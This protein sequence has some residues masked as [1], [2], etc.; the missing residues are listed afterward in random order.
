MTSKDTCEGE[1]PAERLLC[2]VIDALEGHT[3]IVSRSGVILGVNRRW[4]EAVA[5]ALPGSAGAGADFFAYCVPG[6]PLLGPM[7]TE[8]ASR[9]RQV[10]SGESGDQAIKH[11]ME[12]DGQVRWLVVRM[13]RVHHSDAAAVL[14][15]VDITEGMRTQEELRRVTEE[16]T[17]LAL[18]AR[19]TDNAVL[20]TDAQGV[21]E[22]ANDAFTRT[23]G[24]TTEEIVGTRRRDLVR[25]P[26]TRTR[27]FD[28]LFARV[29]AGRSVDSEFASQTKQGRPYWVNLEV[30]PT[31][32]QGRVARMVWVERDVT[33]R[34]ATE[35]QIRQ[36]VGTAQSL[37]EALAHEKV[38][39]AN[40]MSTIPHLVYWKDRDLRYVGCN[41]AFLSARG[42]AGETEVVGRVEGQMDV[43]DSLSSVLPD[44]EQRVLATGAPV[45]DTTVRMSDPTGAPCVL[46]ISVLPQRRAGGH[47]DGTDSHIEGVIGVAS[48]ITH[49]S[50]LERQLAQ[51]A[52]LE[53]IGQLAAGIAHEINTPLQYVCDNTRFV[54]DMFAD[55]LAA[56]RNDATGGPP[57]DLDFVSAEIPGALTQSLEGLDRVRNIVRAMKDFSYPG[58]GLG[59][60]NLN[61]V[62]ES[63][64]QVSRSEWKYVAE[65]ALALDPDL[66]MV[67]CY[68]GELKQALLNIVVNAAQAIGEHRERNGIVELGHITVSTA[69]DGDCVRV[70][71]A[72]DGPGMAEDVRARIFDH[73][74]TT[75]EVGKGTGQGLSM[76]H[77]VVVTKHG[78]TLEV[79][80]AP[81]RGA[82]FTITLPVKVAAPVEVSA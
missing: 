16:A 28:E 26:F 48:D 8:V 1:R 27:E 81:G 70:V 65:L 52:R 23:T 9:M 41:Q 30:R 4:T 39:L 76:A 32:E 79:D 80:S 51:A 62:I 43:G 33:D 38:L 57:L 11:M 29:E 42:L 47:P 21:I 55:I 19:H 35:E 44:L 68:E 75:K 54:S 5:S 36:S 82:M 46:M 49:I 61:R 10:I 67:S 60:A 7:A 37:A 45:L 22:W 63:T 58:T 64:V 74:F 66:G 71:I 12:R 78:G 2:S 72:D 40:V 69:R 56:L 31:A 59:E 17:R 25:G 13:H 6:A 77:S 53:S 15:A 34:R 3:C 20:I 73:F 24:F 18:V 50:E 14:S